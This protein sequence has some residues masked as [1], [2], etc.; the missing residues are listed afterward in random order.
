MPSAIPPILGDFLIAKLGLRNVRRIQGGRRVSERM[1]AIVLGGTGYVAGELLRLIAGHPRLEVAAILSDSQ[2]GASVAG[3]FPHL[4]SAYPRAAVQRGSS[5]IEALIRRSPRA[6]CF[7]P[8]RMAW[9]RRIIDRLLTAAERAG[10]AHALRGYLG[11][12]SLLERRRLRIGVQ[13][14]PRRSRAHSAIYLRG[15]RTPGEFPDPACRPSRLFRDGDL[16]GERAAAGAGT[17][18]P[19]LV[20]HR[21]HRQHRLGPQARR[22]HASSAAPQRSVQPMARSATGTCR[23]SPPARNR[24]R[25]STRNSISCRTPGRS[26]AA[27]TSPCRPRSKNR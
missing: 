8:R 26:P 18:R 21:H 14:C 13:A 11:G 23:K 5:T 2:P 20:R 24:R 9:P 27:S 16:A 22:R 3:A 7:P 15:S 25:A 4:R 10:S 6:R 19:T 12:F 1:P 17:D